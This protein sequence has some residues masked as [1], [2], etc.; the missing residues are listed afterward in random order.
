VYL[1]DCPRQDATILALIR[2][3]N[4]P[5]GMHARSIISRKDI[6]IF[7]RPGQI[8]AVVHRWIINYE[9]EFTYSFLAGTI[10]ELI[11]EK[12]KT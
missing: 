6:V 5:S 4:M 10:N 8:Q 3:G 2:H 1:R 11:Q 12:E 7:R 9:C